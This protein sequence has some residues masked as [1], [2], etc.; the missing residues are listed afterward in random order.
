MILGTHAFEDSYNPIDEKEFNVLCSQT[1]SRT[2]PCITNDYVID[3]NIMACVA[4]P[5]L[6]NNY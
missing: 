5:Q 4:Y 1:L 6:I 3:K 2:V